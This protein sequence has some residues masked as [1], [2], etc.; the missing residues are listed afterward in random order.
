MY[1]AST[2]GVSGKKMVERYYGM[3]KVGLPCDYFYVGVVA[4]NN[5]TMAVTWDGVNLECTGE[6]DDMPSLCPMPGT[7]DVPEHLA[8]LIPQLC[9]Y[10]ECDGVQI[11]VHYRGRY[12][13]YVVTEY[14]RGA[15]GIATIIVND[16]DY[17]V[18]AWNWGT[19]ILYDKLPDQVYD[20][21]I[22]RRLMFNDWCVD[23]DTLTIKDPHLL[24][25]IRREVV[26]PRAEFERKYEV[27]AWDSK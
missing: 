15:M 3:E 18:S 7:N 10:A 14:A 8:H 25:L 9:A 2:L 22:R 11:G 12:Q 5:L 23:D 6:T 13:R 24:D 21:P 27:E 17:E 20:Y 26:L 16:H 19:I 1:I 4:R